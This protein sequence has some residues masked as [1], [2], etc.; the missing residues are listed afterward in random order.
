MTTMIL[1][2]V[3][4]IVLL[5][6]L[7]RAFTVNRACDRCGHSHAAHQHY[8]AGRDCAICDCEGWS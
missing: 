8:R 5:L 2:W 4:V 7:G 3:G 1:L 6:V